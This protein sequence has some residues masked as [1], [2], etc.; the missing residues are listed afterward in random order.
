MPMVGALTVAVTAVAPAPLGVAKPTGVVITKFVV[1]AP[2]GWK[3]VE[4]KFVSAATTTGLVTMVPTAAFE[5]V[6]VT[7]TVRPVRTFWKAWNVSVLGSSA[8][9]ARL[10]A[11]SGEKVV[12]FKFPTNH[13]NP[14]GVRFTVAVPLVYPVAVAVSSALPLFAKLC[15]EK[16]GTEGLPWVR[17]RLMDCEKGPAGVLASRRFAELLVRVSVRLVGGAAAKP[18]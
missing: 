18:M 7:F 9:T 2:T 11:V 4:P 17:A 10:T 5:L 12:V 15:I 6:T 8:P 1:P 13:A 3:V 16:G 14:E